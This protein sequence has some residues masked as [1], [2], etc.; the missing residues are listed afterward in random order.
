[1]NELT[2]HPNVYQTGASRGLVG[3]LE[4]LWV[5]DH[6][7]GDGTLFIVSGFANYNGGV[8]FYDVFR[9]HVDDGGRIVAL[10]GGSTSQRLTS[11]QVVAELLKAGVD[12]HLVN[13]KRLLHAKSYG[14]QSSAGEM[15][16]V[17]S[18]NFTG[19]GMSQ[20]V[21]MSVLLD[22]ATTAALGFSWTDT[23]ASMLRQGWDIHRPDLGAPKDPAWRLLYDEE[24]RALV[25]D[26]TDEVTMIVRL[27]HADTARIL[28]AAGTLAARGSQY[29]WLTKEAFGFFPALTTLNRRGY[30]TTYSTMVDMTFV[31]LAVSESVRVTFEADNNRDFRLGTGPLRGTRLVDEGDLAAITRRTE[32][33][34]ELRLYRQGTALH[35][36]LARHAVNLIGHRG[37]AYGYLANADFERIV[38]LRPPRLQKPH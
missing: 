28:A 16:V 12:V 22:L 8:R 17:T 21:E 11:R 13:R 9:R 37:K 31:D 30:K 2:L 38:G 14:A 15:I 6:T 36:D 10:L 20:N 1:M 7:S 27:G 25:L 29:F 4:R 35:S 3:L 32:R 18:G 19:P 24:D 34:Y 5:R 23:I 26:E 33:S